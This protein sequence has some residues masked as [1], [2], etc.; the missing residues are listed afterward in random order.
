[1]QGHGEGK[2]DM[3]S[4][5]YSW[6]PSPH[7]LEMHELFSFPRKMDKDVFQGAGFIVFGNETDTFSTCHLYTSI[8]PGH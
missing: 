8:L 4:K 2:G 6:T 1:M 7:F 3:V 5:G